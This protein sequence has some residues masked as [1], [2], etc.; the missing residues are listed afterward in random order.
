[1]LER[2]RIHTTVSE[3]NSTRNHKR[4]SH[5][6]RRIAAEAARIMATQAQH[7]YRIA[8]QKAVQRL[9]ISTHTALPSNMEIKNALI[10]Y[11]SFYGGEQHL[12]QINKMRKTAVRV[13]RLLEIFCPRLTGPVLAGT[14][15]QYTPIT[16]HVFND[17][18]DTIA[19]HL[20]D[21]GVTF[22]N[23]LRK[24]RWYNG[25]HHQLPLLII[26]VDGLEVELVLFN[27]LGLRQA[28]PD[29]VDGRPQKRAS[30]AAVERLLTDT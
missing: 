4:N 15:G 26:N 30:L 29:P 13:M 12:L 5:G 10:S 23:G 9:G 28:P 22:Q 3:K 24:T 17:P 8:K 6:R 1:M 7:N 14:A 11:L 25:S 18:P 21:N 20:L 27:R 2:K 16:L 19:I